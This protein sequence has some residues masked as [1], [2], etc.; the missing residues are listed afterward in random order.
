ME[1]SILSI[2]GLTKRY[3]R[4]LALDGL[5]LDIP[6]GTVFGILGPNG[7]GKT[8]TLGSVLGVLRPTGGTYTW[9]GNDERSINK[10][11][12][13]A[14]LEQPNFYPYLSGRQ[15]LSVISAIKQAGEENIDQALDQVR[16]LARAGSRFSTYSF[17]MKQ[18][19]ALAAA[20]LTNPEVV[21]LDEPTNGLDPE[22]IIEVRQLIK[23]IGA[24]GKTVILASHLLDEVEKVCTD[25]AILRTGKLLEVRQVGGD[26][27]S[28]RFYR[29][30]AASESDG[31]KLNTL[32]QLEVISHIDGFTI[33][34]SALS[35]GELNRL[36]FESGI[37]L[38]HL[39][40]YRRSLE[41]EFLEITNR[42]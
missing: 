11:K 15:N 12:I 5:N 29:M 32:P 37:T 30:R 7:S 40:D 6:A 27:G 33:V 13:G 31:P 26:N 36:C 18:R 8:T 24:M 20:L 28:A 4:V 2:N 25:V 22:G 17:G 35:A 23:Q 42:K 10:H 34:Q 1:P 16:L 14:L 3:G 21:V 39:S 38:A 41:D 9:F 19:L